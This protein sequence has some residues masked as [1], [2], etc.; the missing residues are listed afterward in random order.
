MKTATKFDP[1]QVE[2][3]V[4]PAQQEPSL[5]GIKLSGII[6]RNPLE[7]IVDQIRIGRPYITQAIAD[8][9]MDLIPDE[10]KKVETVG[11]GNSVEVMME[12]LSRM[13]TRLETATAGSSD[14]KELRDAFTSLREMINLV[15]KLR[16][17]INT[18][19]QIRA[20]EEAI[21]ATLEEVAPELK[22]RYIDLLSK[23]VE[24]LA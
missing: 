1:G 19:R 21:V 23:K 20:M 18:E 9:L 15:T 3:G 14:T 10:F 7:P 17:D 16:D 24:G 2:D 8:R 4:A 5:E 6:P 22:E 12:K 13:A 11:K